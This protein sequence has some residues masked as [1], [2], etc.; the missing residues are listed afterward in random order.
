MG[1]ALTAS[2]DEVGE[3]GPARGGRADARPCMN[4]AMGIGLSRTITGLMGGERG[5]YGVR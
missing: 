4:S 2:A 1:L 5:D 3:K